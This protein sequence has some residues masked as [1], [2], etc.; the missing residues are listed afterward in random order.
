MSL[1]LPSRREKSDRTRHD[2]IKIGVE[3]LLD[4]E[5]PKHGVNLVSLKTVPTLELTGP[6]RR[7]TCEKGRLWD[8]K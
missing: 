3:E 1:L 6:G 2:Y 7:I 4:I 5:K 8:D